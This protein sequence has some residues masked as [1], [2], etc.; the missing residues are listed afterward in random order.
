M[1]LTLKS[2]ITWTF[3]MNNITYEI[4]KLLKGKT[5]NEK[6]QEL[7]QILQYTQNELNKVV[8]KVQ[9]PFIERLN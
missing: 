2:I 4:K 7:Q 9:V 1:I 3:S 5:D 8:D 6:I